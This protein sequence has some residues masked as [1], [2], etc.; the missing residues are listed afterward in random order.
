M[1]LFHD[2]LRA[3]IRPLQITKGATITDRHSGYIVVLE[4]EIRDDDAQPILDALRMIKGVIS[5][6]PIVG[7]VDVQIAQMHE[8]TALRQ[9]LYDF[10]G[11]LA[12]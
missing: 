7:G 4:N 2:L 9:K 12:K 5:V 8:R 10:I 11:A 1:A 6:E 3:G